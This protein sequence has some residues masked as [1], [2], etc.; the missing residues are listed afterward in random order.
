MP[1]PT[2]FKLTLAYDG[3]G[4]VGWQRQAE[5]VSVQGL[6]EDVLARL[7]A[8]PRVTVTGAGRT[9]AGVHARGQ[10][11]SLI[12]C[13]ESELTFTGGGTESI[14]AVMRGLLAG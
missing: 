13:A 12:H 1:E 10:V 5:G 7:T 14:N 8:A 6:L 11:A 4:L 3:T 9:D 2:T